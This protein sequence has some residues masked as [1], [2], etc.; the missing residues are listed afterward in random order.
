MIQSRDELIKAMVVSTGAD[1]QP[2]INSISIHTISKWT[3]LCFNKFYSASIFL[4][5]NEGIIETNILR[6]LF[7]FYPTKYIE[8]LLNCGVLKKC[9]LPK[10]KKEDNL[11]LSGF[12]RYHINKAKC[13]KLTEKANLFFI[14]KNIYDTIK[15]N[16]NLDRYYDVLTERRVE[17]MNTRDEREFNRLH[18][19][20]ERFKFK[21]LPLDKELEEFE[22]KLKT[23]HYKKYFG[24]SQE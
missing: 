16:V 2:N 12:G 20:Y 23:G 6:K 7:E 17:I 13:Y 5:V 21:K 10:Q 14:N 9:S 3:E 8:R 22:H 1:Y 15:S 18:G 11:Y 19:M 24:G 4:A